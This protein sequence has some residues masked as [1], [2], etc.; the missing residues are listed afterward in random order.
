MGRIVAMPGKSDRHQ[1]DAAQSQQHRHLDGDVHHGDRRRKVGG[2]RQ[3]LAVPGEQPV[4]ADRCPVQTAAGRRIA[5]DRREV[6]GQAEPAVAVPQRHRRVAGGR[7]HDRAGESPSDRGRMPP[8]SAPVVVHVPQHAVPA[9]WSCHR[10]QRVGD[11][12]GRVV[13]QPLVA[14]DHPLDVEALDGSGATETA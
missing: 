4:V 10:D 12:S 6:F 2:Q 7:E 11:P 3:Q 13:Q 9:R 1:R 8:V 5:W 14:I